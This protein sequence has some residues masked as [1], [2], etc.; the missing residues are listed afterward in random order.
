MTTTVQHVA[1]CDGAGEFPEPLEATL[2]DAG[3]AGPWRLHVH[4]HLLFVDEH[5]VLVDTGT[6]P[7]WAPAATWFPRPGLL[8]DALGVEGV[9]P[10]D[11]TDVVFTHLHS[12]HVG[13]SVH[14]DPAAP[15]PSFPNARHLVQQ[16]EV[17]RLAT[18]TARQR[19]LYH[20]HV[21]PLV[22]AGLVE[23]VDGAAV[24]LPQ[25]MLVPSPGHTAGH[26]SVA[27]D[28]PDT[29][30]LISGDV[31]VH[32]VQVTD[33]SVRYVYEDEPATAVRT[34]QQVLAGA[35]EHRTVLATAHFDTAAALLEFTAEGARLTA[36]HTCVSA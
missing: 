28:Q 1:L 27:V 8:L 16:A 18:G 10:T 30:L 13:W 15:S 4:C 33:P 29:T 9:S 12:D 26:Q 19:A 32:P 22:D 34:R 36:V 17:T 2:P 35:A 23:T 24:P 11:V 7:P 14:G 3:L 21:R 5:V 6:G 25:V 31:F 20:T